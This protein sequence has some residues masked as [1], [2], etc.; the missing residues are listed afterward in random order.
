[1]KRVV[2]KD[3]LKK[4][5]RKSVV[6]EGREKENKVSLVALAR[7]FLEDLVFIFWHARITEF[8]PE[9][10]GISPCQAPD[11][12]GVSIVS[13]KTT[14]MSFVQ[15][16]MLNYCNKEDFRNKRPRQA[17]NR[18]Y[19]S[20][21]CNS[22]KVNPQLKTETGINQLIVDGASVSAVINVSVACLGLLIS[23]TQRSV[24]CGENSES[25]DVVSIWHRDEAIKLVAMK[26][27]LQMH[28]LTQPD[29]A[30]KMKIHPCMIGVQSTF[31][32]SVISI[33]EDVVQCK[34]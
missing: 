17:T 15:M 9:F 19:C 5:K 8:S 29:T 24:P 27:L 31:L 28:R 25:S 10:V 11:I 30:S 20:F 32:V 13:L 34:M 1:M 12:P 2:N 26:N 6:V 22:M 18:H 14:P 21:Q 7:K 16:L 33:I 23:R 3:G 4:L